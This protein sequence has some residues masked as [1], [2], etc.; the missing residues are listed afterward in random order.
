MKNDPE[1]VRLHQRYGV[2]DIQYNNACWE[3]N[4]SRIIGIAIVVFGL[5]SAVLICPRT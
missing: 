4:K 2:S 1:F 3:R 5:I